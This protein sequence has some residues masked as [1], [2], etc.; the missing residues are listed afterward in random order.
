MARTKVKGYLAIENCKKKIEKT[1][2]QDKTGLNFVA[3]GQ[4]KIK[5]D[6]I[7]QTK[8]RQEPKIRLESCLHL[9]AKVRTQRYFY[10]MFYSFMYSLTKFRQHLPTVGLIAFLVQFGLISVSSIETLNLYFWL[11]LFFLS[12]FC[13]YVFA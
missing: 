3:T 5:Q 10:T 9:C 12:I 4:H 13:V 1:A 8:T 2:R 7:A 11:I 6:G